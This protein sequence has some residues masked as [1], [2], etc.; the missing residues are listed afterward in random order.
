MIPGRKTSNEFRVKTRKKNIA[1]IRMEG[2]TREVK[3][4]T[5]SIG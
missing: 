3:Y 1:V 2:K 5:K 4:Y